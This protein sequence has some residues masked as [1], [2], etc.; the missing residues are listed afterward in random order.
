MATSAKP[1]LPND[2]N[3][4]QVFGLGMGDITIGLGQAPLAASQ[5]I[6]G[7]LG[8]SELGGSAFI[9]NNNQHL[10]T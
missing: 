5:Q 1:N 10:S 6:P 8:V 9:N 2:D 3:N 4:V 7:S